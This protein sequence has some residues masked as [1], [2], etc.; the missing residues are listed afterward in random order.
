MDMPLIEVVHAEPT[1]STTAPKHENGNYSVVLEDISEEEDVFAKEHSSSSG[2]QSS[3]QE[4][5][6]ELFPAD[7]VC[8]NSTTSENSLVTSLQDGLS[9]SS[10]HLMENGELEDCGTNRSKCLNPPKQLL[11]VDSPKI[12]AKPQRKQILKDVSVY[13]NPGELVAIMGPSGSGKTTLLDLLTGRL[14]QGYSKVSDITDNF[15]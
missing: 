7:N 2:Y 8:F 6:I 14:K 11:S 13:F 4:E 9:D 3:K 5:C 15:A 12:D 1:E 10:V